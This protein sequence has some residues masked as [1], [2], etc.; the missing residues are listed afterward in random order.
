MIYWLRNY[1]KCKWMDNHLFIKVHGYNTK[2]IRCGKI[3]PDTH[4]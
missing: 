1:V 3:K 2:C 4:E